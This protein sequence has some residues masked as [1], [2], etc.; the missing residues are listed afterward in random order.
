MFRRGD[1]D[2]VLCNI[3]PIAHSAELWTCGGV[4]EGR[5]W[6]CATDKGKETHQ[7]RIHSLCLH[8]ARVSS[9]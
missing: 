8:G 5:E 2:E 4:L 3:I 1:S 9:F 7:M 6:Y